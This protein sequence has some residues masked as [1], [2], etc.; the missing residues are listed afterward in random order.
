MIILQVVVL[1]TTIFAPIAYDKAYPTYEAYQLQ[2]ATMY[3]LL[4]ML[5]AI[6]GWQYRGLVK[7]WT[8]RVAHT[9]SW[10]CC[11]CTALNVVWGGLCARQHSAGSYRRFRVRK[12]GASSSGDTSSTPPPLTSARAIIEAVD[13]RDGYLLHDK[14][15]ALATQER[16]AALAAGTRPDGVWCGIPSRPAGAAAHPAAAAGA[17]AG[18]GARALLHGDDD[19]DDASSVQTGTDGEEEGN[20]SRLGWEDALAEID[21]RANTVLVAAGVPH[22]AGSSG[23]APAAAPPPPP[24]APSAPALASV[25]RPVVAAVSAAT[26]RSPLHQQSSPA[27]HLVAASHGGIFAVGRQPSFAPASSAAASSSSTTSPGGAPGTGTGPRRGIARDPSTVFTV[28]AVAGGAA[29]SAAAAPAAVGGAAP[30]ASPATNVRTPLLRTPTTTTAGGL[31]AASAA[32]KP[33]QLQYAP[34]AYVTFAL[35]AGVIAGLF[36]LRTILFL[37]TP[38]TNAKMK[39]LPSAVLYPFFFYVAAEA[40]TPLI[41]LHLLLPDGLLQALAMP[42]Q[43]ARTFCRCCWRA[44]GAGS[45]GHRGRA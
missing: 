13:Q 33:P 11:C 20:A 37:Y 15:V 17:A 24:A 16:D 28:T 26:S 12:G 31:D 40:L 41:T 7:A 35:C 36:F 25:S 43:A 44:A 29:A 21:A 6:V 38:V 18:S 45:S 34:S 1:V 5:Y 10:G 39:G 14:F 22:A 3:L 2:V 19:D 9:V 8:L 30:A 27:G 23:A 42:F 32:V 4:G